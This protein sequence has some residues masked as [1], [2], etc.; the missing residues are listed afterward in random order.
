M[1]SMRPIA[2]TVLDAQQLPTSYSDEHVQE[3]DVIVATIQ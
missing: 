2:G 3:T 1:L